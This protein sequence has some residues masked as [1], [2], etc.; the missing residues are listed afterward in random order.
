MNRGIEVKIK[1]N[2]LRCLEFGMIGLCD[3]GRIVLIFVALVVDLFL[4]GFS[5]DPKLD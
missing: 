4:E 5:T 3:H 1:T 2:F